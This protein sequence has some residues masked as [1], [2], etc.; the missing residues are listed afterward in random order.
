MPRLAVRAVL[1]SRLEQSR[2]RRRIQLQG[3]GHVQLTGV[4]D[5]VV[6]DGLQVVA[7]ELVEGDIGAVAVDR[8]QPACRDDSVERQKFG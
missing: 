7:L 3:I 4:G 1:G 8:T 2:D 5:H 6:Q